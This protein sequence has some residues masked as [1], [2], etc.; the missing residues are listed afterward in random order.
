MLPRY[1]ALLIALYFESD[2]ASRVKIQSA[3]DGYDFNFGN[4]LLNALRTA[5]SAVK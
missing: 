4:R 2:T 5:L 1:N 3:Q